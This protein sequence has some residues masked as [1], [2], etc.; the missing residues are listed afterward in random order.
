MTTLLVT[1]FAE[2]ALAMD[3]LLIFH[4]GSIII[5]DR[6]ENVFKNTVVREIGLIPPVRFLLHE[7]IEQYAGRFSDKKTQRYKPR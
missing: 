5:D 7:T 3:R 1:Q 4:K 2:E 6:P